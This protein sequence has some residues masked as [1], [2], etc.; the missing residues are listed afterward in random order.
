MPHLQGKI[1]IISAKYLM[2]ERTVRIW[3]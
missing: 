1:Y 3:L 2:N